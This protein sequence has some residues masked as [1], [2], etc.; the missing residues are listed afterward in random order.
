MDLGTAVDL[1]E[2]Y[3][4]K[5]AKP[6][7][8][9]RDVLRAAID[10]EARTQSAE[11]RVRALAQQED[12]LRQEV[13]RLTQET[14]LL[15]PRL[16]VARQEYDEGLKTLNASM[17]EATQAAQEVIRSAEESAAAKRAVL[18]ADY[19]ARKTALHAEI[20]ALEVRKRLLEG[21]FA[22]IRSRVAEVMGVG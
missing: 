2:G 1:A 20:E 19:D 13:H 17:K 8:K 14:A 21:E 4:T 3:V 10:A 5:V 6:F 9:V 11:G 15:G 18:D 16:L 22:T 12:D 7:E